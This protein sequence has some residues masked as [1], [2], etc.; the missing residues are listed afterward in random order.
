MMLARATL[1]FFCKL[2]MNSLFDLACEGVRGITP[3]TI[4]KPLA[5]LQR[6]L[7]QVKVIKLAS[8][9]N[10]LGTSPVVAEA[11]ATAT[12]DI[13]RYPDG[14]GFDLKHAL[15]SK[16]AVDIGQITLG[17]GSNEILE[18]VSRAFLTP[19]FEVVFS[20]HSFAVYPLVTQAV[21]ATAQV[22]TATDYCHDLAAM[23]DKITSKTRLIFIA[24]PNNPT[25]TH[26]AP[27]QLQDF[28]ASLPRT[29]ICII[30]EAYYEFVAPSKRVDTVR[31][32]DK[33]PNLLITRTFSKAYG[34]AGLRVGYGLSSKVIADLLNRV[35]QPF[36]NNSLA[37][38]AAMA[39]LADSQ[40]LAKT[41]SC[42]QQGMQQLTAGLANLGLDTIPSN[43]NFVAV[44]MRQEGEAIYHALL[45]KGV[46]VRP[47]ASYQMPNYL[48]VSIGTA[49]E[50]SFFL[51]A[52]GEVLQQNV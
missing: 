51:T 48:R 6:E 13:A 22:A 31:W 11:I 36:N 44:N 27:A 5:Q 19:D 47:V 25:G 45:Q 35:R 37:L 7:G 2:P 18:L 33:F 34:L 8:N 38:T 10:P 15:A 39:A 20:Q 32:L 16:H 49:S 12:A 40:H 29:V 3:Y 17:N 9:E 14:S 41:I 1:N 26:L 42:N 23:A 21:G 52:L 43:A 28:V 24:N 30:D 4:G 46:I 50:N